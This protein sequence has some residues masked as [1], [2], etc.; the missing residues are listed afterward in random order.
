VRPRRSP[1]LVLALLIAGRLPG[2]GGAAAAGTP[3]GAVDALLDAIVARDAAAIEAVACD[4][5]GVTVADALDPI[6]GLGAADGADGMALA[7]AVMLRID[8][9][10]V[11]VVEEAADT[12]TV[13]VAGRLHA[14]VDP[15]IART[16]VAGRL[17]AAGQPTDEASVDASLDAF[18]AALAVGRDLATT[19]DVVRTD[20]DWRVCGGLSVATPGEPTAVRADLCALA[21][22]DEIVA[23]SGLPVTEAWASEDACTWADATATTEPFSITVL[24]LDG[25]LEPLQGVWKPGRDLEIAGQSTWATRNGTWVKLDDGLLAV[26]PTLEWSAATQDADPIAVAVG[27]AEL[28]VP[29]L[30]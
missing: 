25:E 28:L 20:G 18:L 14:A 3:V 17:E 13:S 10:A 16:W 8:D 7:A 24:L 1:L 11:A 19:A 4:G 6:R 5:F 21:S 22:I 2:A 15:E 29:R 12:A 9:R 23:A 26:L 27:V 30:P